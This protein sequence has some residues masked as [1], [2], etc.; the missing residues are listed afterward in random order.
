M[1]GNYSDISMSKN[2]LRQTLINKIKDGNAVVITNRGVNRQFIA[3]PRVLRIKGKV[4]VKVQNDVVRKVLNHNEPFEVCS[5]IESIDK[6]FS[7]IGVVVGIRKAN[8]KFNTMGV[9]PANIAVNI[10]VPVIGYDVDYISNI[11]AMYINGD[12]LNIQYNVK[13]IAQ[14]RGVEI[15]QI[16]IKGFNDITLKNN[17]VYGNKVVG[18]RLALNNGVIFEVTLAEWVKINKM[19]KCRKESEK[20]RN[21]NMIS[22]GDKL[23]TVMEMRHNNILKGNVLGV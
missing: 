14:R 3:I 7:D 8:L 4:P 18:K 5:S 19:E 20:I 13:N 23:M 21:C 17:L 16:V 12:T 22:V 10:E 11:R 2:E 1:S 6:Y 15:K 9:T